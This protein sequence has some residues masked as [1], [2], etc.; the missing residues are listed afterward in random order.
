[1]TYGA[2]NLSEKDILNP[3]AFLKLLDDVPDIR[4]SQA[5]SRRR[6]GCV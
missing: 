5:D 3:V 1:V 2:M 6:A 4:L